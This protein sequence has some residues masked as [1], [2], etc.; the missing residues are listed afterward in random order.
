M[1]FDITLS[2][3]N[4]F[5]N[6]ISFEDMIQSKFNIEKIIDKIDFFIFEFIDEITFEIEI[7]TLFIISFSFTSFSFFIDFTFF[8]YSFHICD[9]FRAKTK[10][11]KNLIFVKNENKQN[12]YK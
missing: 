1:N 12:F 4:F 10:N 7:K 11:E 3:T 5:S 6:L 2:K 9:C 8:F